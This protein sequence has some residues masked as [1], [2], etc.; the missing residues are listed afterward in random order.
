MRQHRSGRILYLTART[1][2]APKN[3]SLAQGP[4]VPGEI[5]QTWSTP[6]G[7]TFPA[8]AGIDVLA[9]THRCSRFEHNR[10]RSRF[11]VLSTGRRVQ[12]AVAL[13][14]D[15]IAYS[16]E[17]SSNQE[18]MVVSWHTKTL[19]VKLKCLFAIY[20]QHRTAARSPH[21]ICSGSRNIKVNN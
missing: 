3:V 19:S 15:F 7:A 16:T 4:A 18:K 10:C 5:P 9:G 11:L 12:G 8:S 17:E 14:G 13:C 2:A 6:G 1:Q 20:L 21:L